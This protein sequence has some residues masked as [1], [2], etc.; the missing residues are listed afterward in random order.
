M[1]A[2]KSTAAATIDGDQ[3]AGDRRDQAAAS[4]RGVQHSSSHGGPTD[5]PGNTAL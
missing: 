1:V 4:E 3:R 2:E 5:C